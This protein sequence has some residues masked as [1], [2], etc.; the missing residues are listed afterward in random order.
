[1]HCSCAVYLKRKAL[2]CSPSSLQYLFMGSSLQ[3][4][5]KDKDKSDFTFLLQIKCLTSIIRLGTVTK[6]ENCH[7]SDDYS[8]I[9]QNPGWLFQLRKE[10]RDFWACW[11][12]GE[13]KSCQFRLLTAAKT[14]QAKLQKRCLCKHQQHTLTLKEDEHDLSSVKFVKKLWRCQLDQLRLGMSLWDQPQQEETSVNPD[15]VEE[16]ALFL[17]DNNTEVVC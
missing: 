12:R 13:T 2:C 1:M 4:N 16:E 8:I 11:E 6:S 5:C 17:R 14:K 10:L 7:L 3:L 9:L 15:H